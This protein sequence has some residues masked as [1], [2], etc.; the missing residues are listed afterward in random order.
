MRMLPTAHAVGYNM[1][2][3]PGLLRYLP[4]RLVRVRRHGATRR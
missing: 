3:L 4:V 1:P 2:P